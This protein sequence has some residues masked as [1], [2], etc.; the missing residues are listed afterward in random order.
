MLAKYFTQAKIIATDIN[1][2]ALAVARKNARAHQVTSRIRFSQGSL[3]AA[4][5]KTDRPDVLISNPPYLEKHELAAVAH[6]PR[7]ALYGGK[8]GLEIIDEL[9]RQ[10][11]DRQI[12]TILIEIAP[13]QEHW[14]Q[15]SLQHDQ[16][17]SLRFLRDLSGKTRFLLLQRK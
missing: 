14:L 10:A 8:N 12:P 7:V 11:M 9:T 3:L 6:E 5:K 17:Y 16:E 2:N 15:Y 4:L 1:K 13:T